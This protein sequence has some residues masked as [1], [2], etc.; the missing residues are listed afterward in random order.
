MQKFTLA[1]HEDSLLPDGNWKLVW[2]DEFDGNELDRTKWA[3]RM[4]MMGKRHYAW[5]DKAVHLDG[6]GN[7][8]FDIIMEDGH[9]V[10]SQLQ[11]GYNFMDEP[12]QQTTFAVC[13]RAV[14]F[15]VN[16]A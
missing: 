5:S 2:N 6:N 15:E 8:V 10:S 16:G 11:T 4:S 12:V 9:P 13:N 3:F 7:V 1:D 14:F